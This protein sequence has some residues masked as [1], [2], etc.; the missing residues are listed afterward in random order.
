[1][2][3][4]CFFVLVVATLL[5]GCGSAASSQQT[6][7]EQQVS[8]TPAE[9]H[10]LWIAAVQTNDSSSAM[11]L[12]APDVPAAP[13]QSSV[14]EMYENTLGKTRSFGQFS[15]VRDLGVRNSGVQR[16]AISEWIFAKGKLCYVLEMRETEDGWKAFNWT[17][18]PDSCL[19]S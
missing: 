19:S 16:Q 12:V 7:V 15:E 10:T 9:L 4:I 14:A 11:K 18:D 3:R 1:M 6:P 5:N 8:Q 13:A 2:V 17:R